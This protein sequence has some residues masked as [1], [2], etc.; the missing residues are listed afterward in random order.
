LANSGKDQ[1][2]R[3]KP[4]IKA[5][6]LTAAGLAVA[7]PSWG[8]D[9]APPAADDPARFQTT[10]NN[11][12]STQGQREEAA[13]R[14]VDHQASP[15]ARQV[16]REVLQNAANPG[17]QII[18]AKALA[19]VANPDPAFVP[20]FS[21]LLGSNR[22]LT[23]AAAGAL[24]N[25]GFT[26][27]VF[28][29]LRNAADNQKLPDPARMAVLRAMGSLSD[30]R[31]AAYLMDVLTR[32]DEN[33]SVQNAAADALGE[34]TGLS[35]KGL[36]HQRWQQWWDGNRNKS[37][38]QWQADLL[39]DRS[40]EARQVKQRYTQLTGELQNLLAQQYALIPE[41]KK[42]DALIGYLTSAVP[43]IRADGVALVL[44]DFINTSQPIPEPVRAQL[45]A[46]IGDSDRNVRLEV[47]DAL[48]TINDRAAAEP[49]IHQLEQETDSQ[50]KDKI[51]TALGRINDLKAVPALLKM[52]EASHFEDAAAAARALA[53]LGGK[54]RQ[55]D[56]AS[57]TKTADALLAKLDATNGVSGSDDLRAACLS[58][59]AT[60]RDPRAMETF[61]KMLGQ[62][63]TSNMRRAALRGLGELGD[64]KADEA[65]AEQ[66]TDPDAGIRL[67]AARALTNTATFAQAEQFYRMLDPNVEPDPD[68]RSAVWTD[69]DKLLHTGTSQQINGWPDR[70]RNDPEKRLEILYALRD[71][72]AK[73]KDDYQLA[74]THQN[75]GETLMKLQTPRPDEAADN[76]QLALNYW[77][78]EGKD[79]GGADTML[80]GLVGQTVDALLAAKKYP[81]AAAFAAK[82]IA[83]SPQ[84]Q[85]T[86]GSR[87][88]N[89]ADRL[90]LAGDTAA[91][92]LL[93][94]NALKMSPPLGSKYQDDL[95]QI[96]SDINR[97]A[98]PGQ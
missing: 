29:D 57:A 26:P 70:F 49:L 54:L 67:E 68:V 37:Q 96:R 48:W 22:Y 64:P 31:V 94:D 97:P 42:S 7:A 14:L 98:P 90:R 8:A 17:N 93:I 45:R 80:D 81:E 73:D 95:K 51:A 27:E 79:Q 59:L 6:L 13:R 41:A 16:L 38:A 65:I 87:L 50:V 35:D 12:S 25:Y 71:A 55:D 10:L 18:A 75:I 62:G 58:A 33:R 24:V 2:V 91:A 66:L 56:P 20:L 84:Y 36:D 52:L 53:D 89:E 46:M 43:E 69:L 32:P 15:P 39:N 86:V 92:T 88:K 1:T 63:Q 60:L 40:R 77:R 30:K 76:F 74:I 21:A 28:G 83:V 61:M 5:V 85:Q 23:E 47:A 9:A 82:Q 11:P 34:L 44:L 4:W 78:G 19:D 3:P 72:Q